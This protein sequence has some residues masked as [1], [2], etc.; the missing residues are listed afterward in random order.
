MV[1][2]EKKLL[3][4]EDKNCQCSDDTYLLVYCSL[5]A[6]PDVYQ[7]EM[8]WVDAPSSADAVLGFTD[9]EGIDHEYLTLGACSSGSLTDLAALS[10][11][12]F[13]DYFWIKRPGFGNCN[14]EVTPSCP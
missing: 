3:M 14:G 11:K 1:L 9:V 8:E 4:T 10:G 7:F 12:A 13:P 6:Q 2:Q 5:Y